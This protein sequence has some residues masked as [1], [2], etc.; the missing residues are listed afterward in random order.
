MELDAHR[1]IEGPALNDGDKNLLPMGRS[2]GS[3]AWCVKDKASPGCCGCLS[4][5]S[6]DRGR[7][8]DG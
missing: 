8:N 2:I 4:S 1:K 3:S 5:A 6:M 7:M